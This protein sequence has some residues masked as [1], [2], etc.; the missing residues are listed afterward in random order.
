[1]KAAFWKTDWFLAGVLTLVMLLAS[2]SSLIQGLERKAYDM[3][4][5][6]SSRTPS[7]RIA[8]I[9]IDDQSIANLGRWPWSRELHAR[10]ADLLAKAPAKVIGNT[11]FFSEAQI[12]PGYAYITRLIDIVAQP[13][14]EG[15]VPYPE[16]EKIAAVLTEAEAA[17]NTDRRL[18]ASYT[19]AGTVVLPYSSELKSTSGLKTSSLT[20]VSAL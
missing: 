8:V 6:A 11:V 12:D 3:G 20:F 1:M 5:Q 7:D 9:A 4:V 10:M 19:Q 15:A 18:A 13:V 14:E 16:A 17:L 2:G